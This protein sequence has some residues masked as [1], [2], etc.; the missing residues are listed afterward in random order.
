VTGAGSFATDD[1]P[2]LAVD[3]RGGV[4]AAGRFG[5]FDITWGSGP[6]RLVLVNTGVTDSGVASLKGLANLDWFAAHS[7]AVSDAS[8]ET[9]KGLRKLKNVFLWKT[10]VSPSSASTL[11]KALPGST[12]SIE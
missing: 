6:D 5:S 1:V 12:I 4:Y 7:T 9:L 10:R 2:G 3:A 8:V 11:Q